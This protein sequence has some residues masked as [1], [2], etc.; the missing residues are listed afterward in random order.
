[1][2]D[3]LHNLRGAPSIM[4][5]PICEYAKLVS[6]LYGY[7]Y[8]KLASCFQSGIGKALCSM[9]VRYIYHTMTFGEFKK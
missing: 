7:L 2:I 5:L 8:F 6:S 1:M 3:N 4:A 9:V